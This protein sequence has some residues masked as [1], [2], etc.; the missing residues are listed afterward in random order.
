MD[1]SMMELMDQQIRQA[2]H[3]IMLGAVELDGGTGEHYETN[4]LFRLLELYRKGRQNNADADRTGVGRHR[5]LG[6]YIKH[7]TG[8]FG[9]ALLT[10]K[11][12]ALKPMLAELCWF[13]R[14]ET[15]VKPLQED[16]CKIWD[17]WADENGELGPVYGWQWRNLYALQ[18]PGGDQIQTLLNNLLER[19]HDSG[20]IVSAW[21]VRDLPGMALRPCHTMWQVMVQDGRLD[22]TLYQRSA[23]WFLGVPFNAASYTILQALLAKMVGLKPGHF[24]HYFGDTHLYDNHLDQTEQWIERIGSQGLAINR[25]LEVEFATHELPKNVPV[26]ISV[27]RGIRPEHIKV[28][29]YHASPAI[30]APVAV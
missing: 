27:L 26:E 10:S 13:L 23:D 25:D 6:G 20:H 14:G 24:H 30:S 2:R 1:K 8:K 3:K 17:E 11:A 9:P 16:G 28:Y 19:P 21:N 15:N 5:I 7:N 12:V 18:G 29:N 4:Y 22:L